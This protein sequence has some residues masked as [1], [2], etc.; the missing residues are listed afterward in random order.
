MTNTVTLPPINVNAAAPGYAPVNK[1]GAQ[2]P[3]PNPGVV[4]KA[5]HEQR[6]Q[7]Y[8]E[9][10]W[11]EMLIKLMREQS[12]H[13]EG[14]EVKLLIPAIGM[15]LLVVSHADQYMCFN[16]GVSLQQALFF[17]LRNLQPYA[18]VSDVTEL[19]GGLLTPVAA[20][21]HFLFGKG[22]AVATDINRISIDPATKTIPVL[23]QAFSSAPIGSSPISIEKFSYD[24]AQDSWLTGA[25]LGNISLRLEGVLHK[26]QENN[27]TFS[28]V[29]RAYDDTYDANRS[30]HR[31]LIDEQATS[32]LAAIQRYLGAVPYSISIRGEMSVV[33]ER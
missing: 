13:M 24:T 10:Y 2:F 25:W 4:V 26:R 33:I 20:L 22:A 12:A 9:G 5:Q 28:G 30:T 11:R 21:S 17:T 7:K 8:A 1:P 15:D 14:G 29:A 19:S 32:V 18:K 3:A 23:E 31:G 16:P 27:F 6:L